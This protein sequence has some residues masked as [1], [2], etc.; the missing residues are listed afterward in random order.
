MQSTKLSFKQALQNPD[1]LS[2]TWELVPGR[3]AWEKSQDHV[4]KMAELAAKD[5]RINGITITD[6]P[7]GKPAILAHTLAVEAKSFGIE[8]IIHFTCKD[9]NRNDIESELYALARS[10]V[11]NLLVMTGDYPS[12]GY[13]GRPKPVFDLD[14]VHALKLINH[15][16]KGED[17]PSYKGRMTLQATNFFA[18]AVV[19]PFK[20]DEAE[21]MNQYYKL[22]KKVRSGAGFIITQLGYDARKFDEL[23]KYMKD[24]NLD[25]PL[26]GNIFYLTPSTAKLM[27]NNKIP[28]CVVTEK[29]LNELEAEKSKYGDKKEVYLL[30]SAK[31]YAILK[32]LGYDGVNISGHGL[33]YWDVCHIIEK[34]EELS[35]NWKDIV[36]E[37]N[38]P[39]KDGFYY[40]V[41]KVDGL[42]ENII[43]D[44]SLTNS[45]G[46][47][48][49]FFALSL[50][51]DL[52][53]R[54]S[55]PLFP[56]VKAIARLIDKS[57][58]KKPFTWLEYAIKS[59]TNECLFCGDC[60][61]HEI[62][63][64][65]P[66]S[67]CPKQQRNGACGGSF[68][69]WCEVYPGKMKCIY[70]KAYQLYKA[71]GAQERLKVGYIPPCDWKLYRTSSWLN[72]LNDR[73]YSSKSSEYIPSEKEK[74]KK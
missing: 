52:F 63:F 43:N 66:M 6:N 23:K 54:R 1:V 10:G 68:E 24:H 19:S 59:V 42:N 64:I 36:H 13:T 57:F 11:Q 45:G 39:Q 33:D 48:P 70:V 32:G 56:L 12:D 17:I 30:R 40:Y 72:Y 3:G 26:I 53:F 37:F 71:T 58:L 55:S 50:V 38:F 7:G 51:H 20:R 44:M 29:L 22:H 2:V 9:K 16:N 14:A 65:C 60:A 34:G 61:M 62:A 46:F 5:Q 41:K 49:M 4:L 47:S 74:A 8:P 25:V 67:K 27:Y 69:G 21:V 31:L 35:A 18:G 28:G 73:D 15:M